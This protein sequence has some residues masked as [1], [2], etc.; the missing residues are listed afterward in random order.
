[1][2]W[3]TWA[4]ACFVN[5]HSAWRWRNARKRMCWRNLSSQLLETRCDEISCLGSFR[6]RLPT[7]LSSREVVTF[8]GRFTRI[9]RIG[10]FFLYFFYFGDSE[11][12][13]VF[14]FFLV[15]SRQNWLFCFLRILFLYLNSPRNIIILDLKKIPK[16]VLFTPYPY[17]GGVVVLR[18]RWFKHA[19]QRKCELVFWAF[20]NHIES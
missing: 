16:K 6:E 8:W 18:K 15:T 13:R 20:S 19:C 3:P 14:S 12:I 7:G 2:R 5:F 9:T 17:L 4:M 10:R 1:M 11:K